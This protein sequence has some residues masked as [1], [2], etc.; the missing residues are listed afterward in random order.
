MKWK[1]LPYDECSWELESDI[2]S[3]LGEIENYDRRQSQ[4]VSA[5]KQKSSLHD[6]TEVK[7][8]QKGFQRFMEQP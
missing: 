2:A 3:I 8:K 5:G 7:N 6:A 1:E 4:K